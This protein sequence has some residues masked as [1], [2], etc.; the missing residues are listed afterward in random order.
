MENLLQDCYNLS[1]TILCLSNFIHHLEL[2]LIRKSFTTLIYFRESGQKGSFM[3]LYNGNT[4]QYFCAVQI[5][6]TCLAANFFWMQGLSPLFKILFALLSLSHLYSYVKRKIGRDGADQV[7][8]L[9]FLAFSLCFLASGEWVKILPLFFIGGQ[10]LI[11]YATS[12]AIKLGSVH[13][14]KGNVLADILGTHSF[15]NG[16]VAA[17]LKKHPNL[18]KLFSHSA[19]GAMLFVPLTFLLPLQPLFLLALACIFMFHISTAL[20]MGLNDFLFTIP[21]MYPAVF[22][23][24]KVVHSGALIL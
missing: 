1:I 2:L 17:Y 20:L 18:E 10:L 4:K 19:I 14:R 21:L 22:Y 24:Y 3:G 6:A 8:L 13:W 16:K 11:L 23:L 15:G 12:G 5:A 9:S 7:R